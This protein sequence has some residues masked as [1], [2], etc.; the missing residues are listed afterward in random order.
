M[1]APLA[2]EI[3]VYTNGDESVTQKISAVLDGRRVT[4][5]SRRI[6][7]LQRKRPNHP[8]ILV[9]FDDGDTRSEAFMVRISNPL[10][11]FHAV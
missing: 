1:V 10:R 4:I 6:V 5:E 9:R 2:K 11:S 8:E 3:V 7:S